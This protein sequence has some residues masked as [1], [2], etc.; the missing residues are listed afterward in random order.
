MGSVPGT[1]VTR[2]Q[3]RAGEVDLEILEAGEGPLALC[4]HGFPDTAHTW[5]H[6]LPRLAEAGFHAVAP[7]MRGYA[8]SSVPPDGAY[9]I[10][11]LVTD[12]NNLH[13]VLGGDESAVIIG[14]DWGA[15]TAYAA[16]STFPALWSKLVILAVPPATAV[17]P[18]LGSYDQMKRS[19]YMAVCSSPGAEAIVSADDFAFLDRLWRD[20]SPGY[21]PTPDLQEVR[22]S[23]G[24]PGAL[25]AALGYYR[26]LFTP[27]D[28]DPYA[29]A[30]AGAGE[31]APQPTLYLHGERDG[32]MGSELAA[33]AEPYLTSPGS[34]TV[35]L[36]DVG[37]FLQV[38]A[39]GPVNDLII[40]HLCG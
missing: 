29:A 22:E 13:S 39:P 30:V 24:K 21:D 37:H 26:A 7:F 18:L 20:W 5:R 19:W 40:E 16:A 9:Q 14:H 31:L 38:E 3:V 25:E 10:G 34:R 8:P 11:A 17:F 32:C 23:L 33:A 2:R 28:I 1:E 36:P 35:I 6:L 12:A 27:Q 4:L 15:G